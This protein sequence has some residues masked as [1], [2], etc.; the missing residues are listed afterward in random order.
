MRKGAFM[1]RKNNERC[2]RK[3]GRFTIGRSLAGGTALF[4]WIAGIAGG[5]TVAGCAGG[6]TAVPTPEQLL[7]AGAL[8]GGADLQA[9]R[10]GRTLFVT[11]CAACHR[12]HP[13]GAYSPEEWRPIARRMAE[14]A[15]LDE[16][17]AEDLERYLTAASRAAR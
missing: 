1:K 15:S 7:A 9:L 14:R 10:R 2:G 13:P 4:L 12:L 8:P 17:Q 6:K 11:E 16:R 5:A 3:S